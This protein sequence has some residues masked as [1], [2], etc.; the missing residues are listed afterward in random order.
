LIEVIDALVPRRSQ[1]RDRGVAPDALCQVQYRDACSG[2]TKN[3][4]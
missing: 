3:A 4:V 1:L 2:F